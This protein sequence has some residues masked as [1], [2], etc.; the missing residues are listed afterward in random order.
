MN[1]ATYE[2]IAY[3]LVNNEIENFIQ[4]HSLLSKEELLSPGGISFLYLSIILNR[5][6]ATEHMLQLIDKDFPKIFEPDFIK[7]TITMMKI[8]SIFKKH[9]N[10]NNGIT[11]LYKFLL[12]YNCPDDVFLKILENFFKLEDNLLENKKP[13]KF[14]ILDELALKKKYLLLLEIADKLPNA[15]INFSRNVPNE[16]Y[17]LAMQILLDGEVIIFNKYL[18][19][20]FN[21]NT[22]GI[23]PPELN[24]NLSECTPENPT[25]TLFWQILT[26]ANSNN[27]RKLIKYIFN[28]KS[29]NKIEFIP[30]LTIV[31]C[32]LMTSI[33]NCCDEEIYLLLVKHNYIK[34]PYDR[35][36]GYSIDV[37]NFTQI[38]PWKQNFL[39]YCITLEFAILLKFKTQPDSILYY[40][41]NDINNLLYICKFL[42]SQYKFICRSKSFLTF[43]LFLD[44]IIHNIN[45]KVKFHTP[46]V[47]EDTVPT[48]NGNLDNPSTTFHQNMPSYQNEFQNYKFTKT[49]QSFFDNHSKTQSSSNNKLIINS[50]EKTL[51]RSSH[52]TQDDNEA[53]DKQKSLTASF[54][55]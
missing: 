48:L 36:L 30:I 5:S 44:E 23:L 39:E 20:Y 33:I 6:F 22:N 42:L 25:N 47:S 37:L 1:I 50:E 13:N 14:C 10:I 40:S 54:K 4:N 12:E 15:M 18:D 34:I 43:D 3:N 45:E 49:N 55:S 2:R 29:D 53:N 21:N 27:S 38:I 31:N 46:S 52:Q 32:N 28:Q 7:Y 17:S 11:N 8:N 24:L 16:N 41:Q 51:E 19:N 26:Q 9:L 35:K